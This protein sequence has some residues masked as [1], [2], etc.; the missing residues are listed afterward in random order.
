MAARSTSTK[1]PAFLQ[2]SRADQHNKFV[3]LEWQQRNR[4]AQSVTVPW[5]SSDLPPSWSRLAGDEVAAR[6]RY[7]NVEPY[8]QNRYR[9]R[10]ADGQNDYINAS[11][12]QVGSRKYIAT[13]GPKSNTVNHFYRMIAAPDF[14]APVVVIML[15]PTHEAGREKC[16]PYYPFDL[17]DPIYNVPSDASCVDGF[18]AK[19]HV[20]HINNDPSTRTENRHLLL[21][22]STNNS[23]ASVKAIFHTLFLGWPDFLVPEGQDRDALIEVIRRS[24]RLNATYYPNGAS[25]SRASD[26]SEQSNPRIIHCSAGVGRSGTFIALDYLI[27]LIDTGAMDDVT[28]DW[29]P[30]FETVELLREQR[31]MMVQGESQFFFLYDVVKDLL[32]RRFNNPDYKPPATLGAADDR[33]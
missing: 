1:L 27:D 16:F 8:A 24:A 2:L 13:Q 19:V 14:R 5:Q 15:T 18:R 30:I 9:L 4:I 25:S 29:D 11:P 6:N 23:S 32:S 22:T 3:D 17:D 20:A 10:V 33:D 7:V 28:K 26:T 21:T 31:M 12:I